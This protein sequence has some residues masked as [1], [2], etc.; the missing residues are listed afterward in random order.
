M[1]TIYNLHDPELE[2]RLRNW[3]AWCK[4][5]RIQWPIS[6]VGLESNYQ[7]NQVWDATPPPKLS[8]DLLDAY[9]IE[10][11]VVKLPKKHRLAL[12]LWYVTR[13]DP[14]WIG[15]RAGTRDVGQLMRDSWAALKNILH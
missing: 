4:P 13:L 7:S 2:P 15:K 1:D 5:A 14:R 6:C 9:K 8:I 11:A 3:A 10:D 12:K